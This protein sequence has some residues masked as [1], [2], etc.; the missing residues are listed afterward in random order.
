MATTENKSAVDPAMMEDPA[1]LIQEGTEAPKPA[2]QDAKDKRIAELEAKLAAAEKK[3]A[4]TPN[5]EKQDAK[6]KRIAELE[7]E[8]EAA[9]K[10]NAAYT[11]GNDFKVVQQKSQEAAEKGLDPWGITVSIRVPARRD[12]ND[13]YY[14]LCVN[15]RSVQIPANNEYQEMKLPFAEALVNMIR[16]DKHAQSFADEEIKVHDPVTNPHEKEEIRK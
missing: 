10:L 15:G 11:K 16:A 9:K 12:S 3:G 13:P 5:P 6:D 1:A 4:E 14:W 8:L 2:E 7:A